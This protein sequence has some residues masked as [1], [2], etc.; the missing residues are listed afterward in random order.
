MTMSDSDALKW[1]A[2][3]GR[4]A[5]RFILIRG[6]LAMGVGTATILVA[7]RLWLDG[8]RVTAGWIGLAFLGFLVLGF[9][10]G[11][12][13]WAL[14]ERHYRAWASRR[15]LHGLRPRFEIAA[16]RRVSA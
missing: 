5:R 4:G 9:A 10:W 6:V 3:R 7:T 14:T 1:E 13:F 2:I 8:D 12:A 16:T 15:K 11:A